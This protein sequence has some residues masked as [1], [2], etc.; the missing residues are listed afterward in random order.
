MPHAPKSM[1]GLSLA[2]IQYSTEN[3]FEFLLSRPFQ[4]GVSVSGAQKLAQ[5]F[6]AELMTQRGS[7]R[8]DPGYGSRLPNELRGY[9]VLSLGDL[10]G[11]LARGI[12][13]V[14]TN[15]RARER[16]TDTLDEMLASATIADLKQRLDCVIVSLRLRTEAGDDLLTRF[17]VELTENTSKN[18]HAPT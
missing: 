9:N 11:V 10:H 5:N 8:F 1:P 3:G 7:V 16:I 13:D 12:D 4:S 6:I 15:L 17:P 18:T 14:T 2:T